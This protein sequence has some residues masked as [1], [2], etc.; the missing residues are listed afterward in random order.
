MTTRT[1][2]TLSLIYSRVTG[3]RAQQAMKISSRYETLFIFFMKKEI[4]S[5]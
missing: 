5:W 4:A 1:A 2:E 3:L